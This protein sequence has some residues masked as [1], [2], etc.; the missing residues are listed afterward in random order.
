VA[1]SDGDEEIRWHRRA[2]AEETSRLI[3]SL[4]EHETD[5]RVAIWLRVRLG[6]ERMTKVAKDYGY[7][8]GSGVHRVL[9]RLEEKAQ[10]DRSLVRPLNKLAEQMSSVKS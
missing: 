2:S 5:R 4:V 10:H 3:H 6:G 8:D 1:D 7:R 9:Q